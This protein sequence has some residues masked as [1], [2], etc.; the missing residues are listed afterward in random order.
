MKS[1][2]RKRI[3]STGLA[4]LALIVPIAIFLSTPKKSLEYKITSQSELVS[5]KTSVEG[6]EIKIKGETIDNISIY[7]LKVTNS[8]SAPILANDFEKPIS[9]YVEEN[10]K[11][12]AVK[13][14]QLHPENLSLS[15]IIKD[16]FLIVDPLLLNPGDEFEMDL[17]S[18]SSKYP[19]IDTRI[20]G[21]VKVNSVFPEYKTIIESRISLVLI[22]LLLVYYG[23]AGKYLISTDNYNRKLSIRISNILLALTCSFSSIFLATNKFH[24]IIRAYL[25]NKPLFFLLMSIPVF[26]GWYWAKYE[27][28]YNKKLHNIK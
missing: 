8:G 22:F 14:K 19:K 15:H 10:A 20:A 17:Y 13:I 5:E 6:L 12:Y 1:D 21:I 26:L 2:S 4:I 24:L 16:D 18:S 11:I 3:I 27:I 7:G 28:K 23:K 9:I 25:E